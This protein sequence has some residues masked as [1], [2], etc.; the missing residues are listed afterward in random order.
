[1]ERVKPPS[2]RNRLTTERRRELRLRAIDYTAEREA[3]E[4]AREKAYVRDEPDLWEMALGG[5]R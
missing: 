2:P 4:D 3:L 5:G 1:M